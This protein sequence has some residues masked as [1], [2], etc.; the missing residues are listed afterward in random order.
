[1]PAQVK[2]PAEEKPEY[3]PKWKRL[4]IEN[5]GKPSEF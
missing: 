2:P 3:I 5:G 4:E 1:M